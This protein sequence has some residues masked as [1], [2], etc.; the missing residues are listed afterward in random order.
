MTCQT[1]ADR[2]FIRIL[3]TRFKYLSPYVGVL[4]STRLFVYNSCNDRLSSKIMQVAPQPSHI[5]D[6]ILKMT[7]SSISAGQCRENDAKL[8][9][10][11]MVDSASA[12]AGVCELAKWCRNQTTLTISHLLITGLAPNRNRS[13][14]S[15][16][17]AILARLETFLMRLRNL[18][19]AA[20][21]EDLSTLI[22]EVVEVD[23]SGT[24]WHAIKALQ[25]DILLI[26]ESVAL[27]DS[28]RH[29]AKLG[30]TGKWPYLK[31]LNP[32]IGVWHMECVD[33]SCKTVKDAIKWRNQSEINPSI[34]T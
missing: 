1:V 23:P 4:T 7:H 14:S 30:A 24:E 33:R 28:I 21:D 17:F 13:F 11:L 19:V 12:S 25:L 9:I 32:S 3:Y 26:A 6:P 10:G 5:A 18:Q 29:A 22:Q 15:K 8:K 31:M 34:L 2:R 16:C 27:P 20:T